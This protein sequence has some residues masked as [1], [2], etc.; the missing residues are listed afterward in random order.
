MWNVYEYRPNDEKVA[1]IL[2]VVVVCLV[3]TFSFGYML[4]IRNVHD[5]GAG[6]EPIG[7]QFEQV[8]TNISNAKEGI[9]SA[10]NHIATGTES[11]DYLQGTVS[12]SAELVAD[13]K[14]IL[15]EIRSRGKTDKAAN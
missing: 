15:A 8:G 4:G 2:L 1:A 10:Q 9:D 6:T 3:V 11:V 5:N 12:T 13:C 7:Q 14:R